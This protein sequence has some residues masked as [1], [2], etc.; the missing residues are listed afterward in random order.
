MGFSDY[1]RE[2]IGDILAGAG[3]WFHADLIRLVGHADIFNRQRLA[4]AFPEVVDAVCQYQWG[5]DLDSALEQYP[6]ERL[7]VFET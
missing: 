3:D 1:D 6:G 7:G 4:K 2:H 5:F